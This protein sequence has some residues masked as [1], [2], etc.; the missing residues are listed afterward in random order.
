MSAYRSGRCEAAE[1]DGGG[2]VDGDLRIGACSIG[3]RRPYFMWPGLI[4]GFVEKCGGWFW[5]VP[6]KLLV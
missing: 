1:V 6:V 2:A 5:E 4:A 3:A